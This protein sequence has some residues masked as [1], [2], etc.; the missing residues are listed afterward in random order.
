MQIS[1]CDRESVRSRRHGHERLGQRAI[2]V[3]VFALL[4]GQAFAHAGTAEAKLVGRRVVSGVQQSVAFT[5]SSGGQIWV[6]EKAQGNILVFNPKSGGHHLFFH[7]SGVSAQV[8]QGLVGIAL[9]PGFPRVPWVY[10]FATRSVGGRLLD[11]ILRIRSVHEHGRD[12]HVMFSARASSLHEHSG[13][14]ILFGPDRMLYVFMGDAA[15]PAS[16]Q[17][18]H[19]ARGKILRMTPFGAIPKDNPSRH[20]RIYAR[21]FRNSFGMGFDP[22]TRRLWE[23]EN[24]P[25]CNDELNLVR[26]G[27]N[28]GWGPSATCSGSSPRDTNQDGPDPVLP[29]RWYTPT[30]APTGLAFCSGCGLGPKSEGALFFGAYKTGEIRRVRLSP[31]RKRVVRVDVLG[32]PARSILSVEVGPNGTL[33]YSTYIGV[34]RLVSR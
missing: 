16:A 6:V 19:S 32:R 2:S 20:S 8:E 25:E 12:M 23:T 29:Q 31:D 17:S 18:P 21:G 34:Y 24:G 10:V 15:S 27:G 7:V 33:Y 4:L 1:R 30:I 5:I 9:H 22:R 13:G 26:R 28:F 3:L 11:Q 14:R